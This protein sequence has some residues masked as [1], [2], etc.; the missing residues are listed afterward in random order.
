MSWTF[1]N[2]KMCMYLWTILSETKISWMHREPLF[3]THIMVLR[4]KARH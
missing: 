4:Y 2:M 3:L 1:A